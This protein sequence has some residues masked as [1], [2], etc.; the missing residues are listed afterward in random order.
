MRRPTSIVTTY[1]VVFDF[2]YRVSEQQDDRKK[3]LFLD[4]DL[5]NDFVPETKIRIDCFV[6]PELNI[7]EYK[8][9]Y[10]LTYFDR[11]ENR[12]VFLH[13]F[14]I[15]E[16]FKRVSFWF[17]SSDKAVYEKPFSQIFQLLVYKVFHIGERE[18]FRESNRF[19]L[20]FFN[21]EGDIR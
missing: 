6:P 11:V 17:D 7:G 15:K 13:P 8:L 10:E 18:L 9:E 14:E 19:L 12:M 4:K 16:G 20:E 21:N 2:L 1:S 3:K 5:Y